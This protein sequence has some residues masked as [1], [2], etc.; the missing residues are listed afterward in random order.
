[1]VRRTVIGRDSVLAQKRRGVVGG[2]EDIRH[3]KAYKRMAHGPRWMSFYDLR[4]PVV[5]L[6]TVVGP[7]GAKVRPLP[8]Y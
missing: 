5:S 3:A 2:N 7:L 6:R 1:M 8:R 4:D